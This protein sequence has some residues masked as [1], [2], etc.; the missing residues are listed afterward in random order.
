MNKTEAPSPLGYSKACKLIAI[1]ESS[2]NLRMGDNIACGSAVA[3]QT[4]VIAVIENL[5]TIVSNQVSLKY[6][7]FNTVAG[8]AIQNMR[9]ADLRMDDFTSLTVSNSNTKTTKIR[10]QDKGHKNEVTQFSEAVCSGS[11]EPICFEDRY[12]SSLTTMKE[13]QRMRRQGETVIKV[14]S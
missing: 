3:C 12:F 6:A 10:R 7:F 1:S 8:I 9:P 14:Y 4:D 2:K 13:I 5:C 11:G